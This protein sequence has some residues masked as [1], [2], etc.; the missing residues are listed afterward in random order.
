[1]YNYD[2]QVTYIVQHKL[3]QIVGTQSNLWWVP[4]RSRDWCLQDIIFKFW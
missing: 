1:M 2:I 3:V 4:Q